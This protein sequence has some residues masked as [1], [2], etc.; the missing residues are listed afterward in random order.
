M[1]EEGHP[2]FGREIRT[3]FGAKFVYCPAGD[4]AAA[5]SS[6]AARAGATEG[7][8]SP[9]YVGLWAQ[10]IA[11]CSDDDSRIAITPRGTNEI[12]SACDFTHV[13]GKSGRWS[14]R[15]TCHMEGTST[16]SRLEIAVDG[17]T[18]TMSFPGKKSKVR[19]VRCP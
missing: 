6:N 13:T 1:L 4:N 7:V 8:G 14:M 18:M 10:K 9:S 2:D 19:L 16:R 5:P 17:D 12:E 3:L 11:W 15:Q